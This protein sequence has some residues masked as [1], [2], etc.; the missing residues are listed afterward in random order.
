MA[1]PRIK[2]KRLIIVVLLGAIAITVA[3]LTIGYDIYSGSRNGGLL[4]FGIVSLA[5][6]LFFLFLPVELAF[7]YY[8]A[9]GENFLLLN[10]VALGT[11]FISQTAD[12]LIGYLFSTKIID[13]LIGRKRY[14]KAESKIK[15]FGN[16]TIFIFNFFRYPPR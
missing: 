4:S 7:I 2:I 9:G 11:A 16:V 6:Y 3:S 8:L 12:Y 13:Q 14:E 10:L 5:G 1:H 15:E